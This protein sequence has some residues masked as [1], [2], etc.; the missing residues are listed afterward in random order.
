M[1]KNI[2]LH[3]EKDE[4]V[5]SEIESKASAQIEQTFQQNIHAFKTFIPSLIPTIQEHKDQSKSIIYNKTGETNIVDFGLGR[6]LYGFHPKAEIAAQ[7]QQFIKHPLFINLKHENQP[8]SNVNL[9]ELEKLKALPEL[10]QEAECIVMLGCGLGYQIE[11]LI[12]YCVVKHLIIYE[13]EPQYFSASMFANNWQSILTLAN[14]KGIHLYFQIGKDGRDLLK[15]IQELQGY[16]D[17][18]GLYCYKHFNS[19]VYNSIFSDLLNTSWQEL[20]QRGINFNL[21]PPTYEYSPEW[22]PAL[23][24]DNS[25]LVET[26]QLLF[27]KNLKALEKYYPNVF[28]QFTGY[29]PKHWL[30]MSTTANQISVVSKKLGTSWFSAQPKQ[31]YTASLKYFREHPNKDGLSLGYSG[32]KLLHYHH[33]KFVKE[34]ENLLEE[35]ES[36]TQGLPE[37]LPALILFGLGLGYQIEGILASHKVENLFICEP[38]TDLFYA[39]LYCI[40]WQQVFEKI[41]KDGCRLYLNI[42]DDG[43]NLFR[44]LVN[45]FY[46]I[47]PYIL[48]QTYFYQGYYNAGLNSAINQLR[49]QL[50]VVISVGEYFDHAYYGINH[51]KEALRRNYPILSKKPHTLFDENLKDTPVFIVGNGPSMDHSIDTIKEWQ[52]KAI[53]ISCGTALQVF[54]RHNIVPDFHAEIEQNRTT[55][56][57]ACDIGDLEFLK[58]VDLVSCNGIHP[59]TCDLYK[60]TYLVFKEGE[61]STTSAVKSMQ[62]KNFEMLEYAFPTVTNFAANLFTSLGFKNIY[63]LG[64]DLG[65]Y[66]RKHHHSKSSAYYKE[67]GSELGDYSEHYNTSM[68]VTGNFRPHVFTKP[69]FKMSIQILEKTI[70][71]APQGVKFYNCSDGAKI[72]GAAPLVLENIL[73]TTESNAGA[74]TKIK[75]KAFRLPTDENAFESFNQAFHHGALVKDLNRFKK[76]IKTKVKT[77]GDV[78]KLLKVQR[79][80]LYESYTRN[81]SLFFYYF[82]GTCNYVSAVLAKTADFTQLEAAAPKVAKRALKSWQKTFSDIQKMLNKDIDTYDNSTINILTREKIV[83]KQRSNGKSL[84]IVHDNQNTFY[85]SC[86]HLLKVYYKNMLSI[87]VSESNLNIDI[88]VREHDFVMYFGETTIRKYGKENTL[89][90]L[91]CNEDKAVSISN[92]NKKISVLP[93]FAEPKNLVKKSLLSNMSMAHVAMFS[94]LETPIGTITIPKVITNGKINNDTGIPDILATTSNLIYE[95]Y[96][97]FLIT[98]NPKDALSRAGTR[99]SLKIAPVPFSERAFQTLDHDE[100]KTLLNKQM[101]ML[102]ALKADKFFR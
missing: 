5:Q 87:E 42:G 3:I 75:T 54:H 81:Q 76:I 71:D 96:Y 2:S 61:S 16:S 51:T 6:V 85:L 21:T 67:D 63:L 99:G 53:I 58:K 47:G 56:D 17:I 38:N 44:D 11:H 79:G 7:Y 13:A 88:N 25:P 9:T 26:T 46:T 37:T 97:Y 23:D 33:Y 78:D 55:F 19:P 43:S 1:L 95:F 36:E 92:Q 91:Q 4:I 62:D 72:N 86:I 29:Q 100:Y 48:N 12:E 73:S 15:D 98:S 52:G 83:L 80:F 35:Y 64:V 93:F 57:W 82:Y 69:E 45:Q 24:L 70:A 32:E 84:L 49:E 74:L 34:T 27:R 14:K 90:V 10:S 50:R 77:N 8:D 59:D 31:D 41:D 66:D 102:P 22:T 20:T 65:F 28:E 94:I 68:V 30:P 101:I 40:D 89:L 60:N 18:S 39:S